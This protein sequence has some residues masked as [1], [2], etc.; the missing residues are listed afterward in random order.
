M[1][2]ELARREVEPPLSPPSPPP[3]AGS[4]D[5]WRE[6]LWD[7]SN[8]PRCAVVGRYNNWLWAWSSSKK[9]MSEQRK[10]EERPRGTISC[11][12]CFW[13][14]KVM[15]YCWSDAAAPELSVWQNQG[16]NVAQYVFLLY[17]YKHT[18]RFCP[19]FIHMPLKMLRFFQNS[20]Q[21]KCSVIQDLYFSWQL[22]Q[23][24]QLK[25]TKLCPSW[26]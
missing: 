21:R 24:L 10:I 18:Q 9:Q 13:G 8:H 17:F 11:L 15:C 2:G 3:Q 26:V 22:Q 14:D 7:L 16:L 20:L 4:V 12:V 1:G 6:V 5:E 19:V 23:A 25:Q